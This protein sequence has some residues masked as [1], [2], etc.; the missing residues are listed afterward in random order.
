M[1]NYD[2][3]QLRYSCFSEP[4]LVPHSHPRSL[5]LRKWIDT[6]TRAR[7]V[8]RNLMVKLHVTRIYKP[9]PSL[10]LTMDD[11]FQFSERRVECSYLTITIQCHTI[12]S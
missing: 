3:R 5:S 6:N 11:N 12:T 8:R 2:N 1:S 10:L 4:R 7:L 9:F